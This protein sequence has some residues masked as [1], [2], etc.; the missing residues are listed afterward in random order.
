MQLLGTACTAGSHGNTSLEPGPL[1]N[2]HILGPGKLGS[3]ASQ[4]FTNIAQYL[5]LIGL[6][7]LKERE[8][9][10]ENSI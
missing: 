2:I 1:F 5:Q 6:S 3:E 8:K 7:Y 10:H 4:W 9:S